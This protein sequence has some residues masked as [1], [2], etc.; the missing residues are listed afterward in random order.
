MFM[1]LLTL[2]L[3]SAGAVRKISSKLNEVKQSVGCILYPRGGHVALPGVGE[4]KETGG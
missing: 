1:V 4:E 3:F 2:Y